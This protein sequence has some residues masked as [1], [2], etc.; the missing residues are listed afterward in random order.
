[1][2]AAASILGLVTTL[3]WSYAAAS[4]NYRLTIRNDSTQQTE[5]V[6][7]QKEPDADGLE[8]LAW[9]TQQIEPQKEATFLWNPDVVTYFASPQ[10][11]SP[12]SRFQPTVELGPLFDHGVMASVSN[13]SLQLSPTKGSPDGAPVV[14]EATSVGDH[15]SVALGADDHP[16]LVAEADPGHAVALSHPVEYFVVTAAVA[17]GEILNRSQISAAIR[18]PFQGNDHLVAVR[19][20]QKWS[21]GPSR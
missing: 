19:S 7:F 9:M 16:A 15:A 14:H 13:G 18:V 8:S 11:P 3:N 6:L 10:A 2:A 21:F 4:T 17:P 20:R 5:V 1:M 12:G